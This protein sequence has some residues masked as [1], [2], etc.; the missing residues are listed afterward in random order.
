MKSIS[1]V[2]LSGLALATMSSAIHLPIQRTR[3]R[4]TTGSTPM[5]KTS[6]AAGLDNTQNILYT[7]DVAVGAKTYTL[8]LDTGSSDLWFAPDKD[9]NQTFAQAKIYEPLQVNLTYGTGWAAGSVA[10]IDVEFAGFSIKNQSLLFITALSEWD[11][12]FEK[13]YPIY[14]GIAGLSFDTLS[15]VNNEVY[16]ATNDTWGRSLMSNVLLSDPSTPNHIAFFLDRTG[17][18]NDTDTGLFD[19]GTYAAG[20]ESIADQPKHEVFSGHAGGNLHWNILI[21]GITINGT[22][23]TLTSGVVVGS[24]TGITNAPPAGSISAL[25]D[26][27]TS[28]AQLPEAVFTALYEGMGGVLINGTTK[29]AVPCMAEADLEFKIGN[30]TAIVHPLDLTDV[31]VTDG[32]GQN[33]TFC[34][35][36]YEP[37]ESGG[38][39]LDIILGDA[40]LRNVYA[41]YNYGNFVKDLSGHSVDT[42]F[43]QI[44]PLT[45]AQK[46][47]AE[48]KEVRTKELASLPPQ[49]DVT[50]VNDPVPKTASSSGSG[51]GTGTGTSGTGSGNTGAGASL[52]SSLSNDALSSSSTSSDDASALAS[53]KSLANLAPIALGLLGAGVALLLVLIAIVGI[54]MS[55]LSKQNSMSTR[56]AGA[57]IPVALGR[58]RVGEYKDE[59]VKYDTQFRD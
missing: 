45:D 29:Y 42:P 33:I 7:A 37:G 47:S 56:T 34:T 4:S 3:P 1:A 19:I 35:N 28:A 54:A 5:Q 11:V 30:Q 12:E 14:R 32:N 48:F 50:T 51:S 44:L 18:L 53:L 9:Y 25:L 38:E 46:A 49:I 15:Q 27:G 52:G 22:E 43:I 2:A 23:Q 17:D 57:Y 8:Q 24:S 6:G 26:T 59:P 55:R 21:D 20:Y 31:K 13:E 41:L 10:Q 58:E 39:D 16:Q 40:F 36:A